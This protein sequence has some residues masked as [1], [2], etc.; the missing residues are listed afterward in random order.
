MFLVLPYKSNVKG[1]IIPWTNYIFISI[2]MLM[3]LW[4]RFLGG[5]EF[6]DWFILQDWSIVSI[7]GH[8]WVH[9]SLIHLLINVLYLWVLGNALCSSIGNFR[10][11]IMYLLG[12]IVAAS[13]YLLFDGRPCI[14]ASG[15]NNFIIVAMCLLFPYRKIHG[16]ILFLIFPIFRF[17]IMGTWYLAIKFLYEL[18]FSFLG[19]GQIAYVMHLSGIIGGGILVYLL[20]KFK[21]LKAEN[22]DKDLVQAIYSSM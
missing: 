12:G 1:K 22:S 17:V 8:V 11:V 13:G 3:F 5:G 18:L 6:L 9:V 19:F 7:L 21:I 15:A 2:Q 14:G 20:I 16:C 4:M 10:F